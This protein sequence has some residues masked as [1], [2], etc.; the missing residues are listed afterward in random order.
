MNY[1]WALL[2]K[3]TEHWREPIG[4]TWFCI[5]VGRWYSIYRSFTFKRTLTGQELEL[6]YWSM[7]TKA[8]NSSMFFSYTASFS[9]SESCRQ[10]GHA[11][12]LPASFFFFLINRLK[13]TACYQIV[14]HRLRADVQREA[15]Q[16]RRVLELPVERAQV[17]R[18]KVVLGEGWTLQ[19]QKRCFNIKYWFISDHLFRKL[20]T[21][22]FF[23]R[24]KLTTDQSAHPDHRS[25]DRP[26]M[27]Y[28]RVTI[29]LVGIVSTAVCQYLTL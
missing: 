7:S 23:S 9:G 10:T 15:G 29:N 2:R 25:I 20:N 11:V 17:H 27:G 6:L 28:S 19:R 5:N 8:S 26:Q 13:E 18:Q 4:A 1:G 21:L 14:G 12:A 3:V 24:A 22:G 16:L